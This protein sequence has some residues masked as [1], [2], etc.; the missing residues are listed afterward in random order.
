MSRCTTAVAYN[1]YTNKCSL[2]ASIKPKLEY[3]GKRMLHKQPM[4]EI[5]LKN[6]C[7]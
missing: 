7:M 5:F 2:S 1:V 3:M 6:N 4:P